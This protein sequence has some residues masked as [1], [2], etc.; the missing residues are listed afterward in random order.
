[1]KTY[2]AALLEACTA[3]KQLVEQTCKISRGSS[4]CKYIVCDYCNSR[5]NRICLL[6]YNT[7]YGVS[8]T[9]LNNWAM[10]AMFDIIKTGSAP[11]HNTVLDYLDKAMSCPV[12]EHTLLS[13]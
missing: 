5:I 3:V 6:T 8:S 12:C 11:E 7:R 9:S 1:M 10:A 2:D 13:G 4:R